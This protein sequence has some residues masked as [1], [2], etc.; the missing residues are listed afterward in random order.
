MSCGIGIHLKMR[1]V[2]TKNSA[3][4]TRKKSRPSVCD[5]NDSQ[6]FRPDT[7]ALCGLERAFLSWTSPPHAD[8]AQ[9]GFEL[10]HGANTLRNSALLSAFFVCDGNLSV[11][12]EEPSWMYQR[13][14]SFS[15]TAGPAAADYRRSTHLSKPLSRPAAKSVRRFQC[16]H[17]QAMYGS[18]ASRALWP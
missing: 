15:F 7:W 10:R 1:A 12:R 5:S 11:L 6:R 13:C 2:T 9:P 14:F 3:I 8:G 17:Q 16:L 4:P 18:Q